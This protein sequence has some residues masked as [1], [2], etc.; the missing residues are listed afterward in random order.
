MSYD[1]THM[2]NLKRWCKWAYL[3]NSNG[4]TDF[5]NKFMVTK[6]EG[7][8]GG[9]DWGFGISICTLLCMEWMINRDW[10]YSQGNLF[11][12]LWSLYFSA[13]QRKWG[14]ESRPVTDSSLK[15]SFLS[16]YYKPCEA[17]DSHEICLL[18]S[19]PGEMTKI[20]YL[21]KAFC[22]PLDSK[23]YF[24]NLYNVPLNQIFFY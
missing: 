9:R 6:A 7:L 5:E 10:Q 15:G 23:C 20:F 3:Q 13:L 17:T 8:R 19:I 2:C 18:F 16:C 12:V 22:S 4:L 1:I 24:I 11:N 21:Y 14:P